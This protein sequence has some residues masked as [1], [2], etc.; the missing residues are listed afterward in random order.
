MTDGVELDHVGFERA[1]RTVLEDVSA[2]LVEHRVGLIGRNGSGK[3]TLLRIIGALDYATSGH[4]RIGGI[5]PREDLKKVR[6]MVGYLFQNPETQLVL[7]RVDEDVGLGLTRGRRTPDQQ[8][9]VVEAL[10]QFGVDHLADRFTHQLSGGEQQLVALAGVVVREPR[11]LLLDEPTT[12]LDLTYS[13]RMRGAI[14]SLEQQVILASHDLDLIDSCDRVLVID[15]A[16]VSFDGA[17]GP[18]I[19]HYRELARWS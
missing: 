11:V 2:T 8:L 16:R 15:N 10:A 14:D 12:H 6:P 19:D 9:R 3:T 18:A 13:Q 5:D 4:V 7:P 1:R 17:P